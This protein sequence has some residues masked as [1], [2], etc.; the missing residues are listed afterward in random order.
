MNIGFQL[1]GY[2]ILRRVLQ[3]VM[4]RILAG[5]IRKGK[6]NAARV[7][8]RL[9]I[10]TQVRPTGR[11][12][13]MHAVG[14]GEVLAL[15]PFAA[16]I[17]S[18]Q[19]AVIWVPLDMMWTYRLFFR[20]CQPK[21]GLTLEVEVWPAMISAAKRAGCPLY[22]CNGQYGTKPLKS[23]SRGLRI[24]QRVMRGLTG[25][26]VKSNLQASRFVEVGVQNVHV[27]GELRFD[28]PIP[29]HQL[30][31]AIQLRADQMGEWD[32][33]IAIASGIEG[34]EDLFVKLIKGVRERALKDGTR[35]PLFVYV[36]RAPE[37]FGDVADK[38]KQAGLDTELRSDALDKD[39]AA[40]QEALDSSTAVLLGDS[41]G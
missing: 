4:R 6:E 33:I 28:Q 13:W 22:M 2:L 34:E 19:L 23:D 25:V 30:D 35:A 3:P 29:Q 15:H 14:L 39:L 10:A 16:E 20:A 8:E 1:R 17:E 37:R 32:N 38:L 12:V 26:F 36:P 24:R 21:I 9:G 18:G 40:K 7:G 31:A 5:R 27:T 41:L 11:V